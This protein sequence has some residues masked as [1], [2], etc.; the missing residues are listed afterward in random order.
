MNMGFEVDTD[1]FAA[2]SPAGH[3]LALRIGFAFPIFEQNLLPADWVE[4]YGTHGYVLADPVMNWLYASTGAVRWSEIDIPDHRGVLDHAAE[5]GL[6]Y[7][8]AVCC[9]DAGAQGQRSF[10]SFARS[11]REFEDGE[12]AALQQTL[13]SLH[14][15]LVP[16]RNLTRAELEALG[17]VKNGLLMKEIADLLS[18]SEGAVKQRLKNAKSKLNA[19]TSTHAATMATSY[20]LI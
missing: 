5:Y 18:V 9:R 2:L 16:P 10:G 15:S 20:G 4:C 7:G 14:D 6:A 3:F 17:M 1:L 19:K 8:V 11:D 12:I 13:Q